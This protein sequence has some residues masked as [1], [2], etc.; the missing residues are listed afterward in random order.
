MAILLDMDEVPVD[1]TGAALAVHGY[2]WA[3][4]QPGGRLAHTLGSWGLDKAM[5]I[6][7]NQFWNPIHERG[8]D[9]WACL[10]PLPWMRELLR[11]VSLLTNEWYIVTSPSRGVC[12]R[13][14]KYQWM[15]HHL[16]HALDRLIITRHKHLLAKPGRILVDDRPANLT[17]FTHHGGNGVLFPAYNNINRDHAKDPVPFV[18]SQLF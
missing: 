9:F 14:G 8:A 4:F 7:A 6:T 12:S 11:R 16:P 13:I 3:D 2:S 1:F 5:D 17:S 15:D 18:M 10:K